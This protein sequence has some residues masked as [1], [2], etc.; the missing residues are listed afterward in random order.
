MV[1]ITMRTGE[2]IYTQL[3]SSPCEPLD[4]GFVVGSRSVLSRAQL[5]PSDKTHLNWN[6]EWRFVAASHAIAPDF[7]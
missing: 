5:W 6:G 4:Q 3:E 1:T 2:F 7:P